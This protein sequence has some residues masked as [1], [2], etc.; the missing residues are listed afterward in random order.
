MQNRTNLL[1]VFLIL[2]VL[3]VLATALMARIPDAAV[4]VQNTH[5][6]E[7]F[8]ALIPICSAAG[9][10]KEIRANAVP[11]C[12]PQGVCGESPTNA[13]PRTLH[14]AARRLHGSNKS[15]VAQFEINK[16]HASEWRPVKSP[17]ILLGD[18]IFESFL[19]TSCAVKIPRAEGC[20]EVLAETYGHYFDALPLAISGDQT[21]H[22][23]WRMP[24]EIPP[25]VRS[26]RNVT[27]LVLIGTNNLGVGH[28][29]GPTADGVRAVVQWL[30]D[31]TLGSVVLLDLL[32]RGD[33]KTL[34][35]LCPPRCNKFGHAFSSFRSPITLVN[36]L[37]EALDCEVQE[38]CEAMA[39]DRLEVVYSC[40]SLFYL[41]RRAHSTDTSAAYTDLENP[42]RQS[43]H[44]R[45]LDDADSINTG[46]MPDRLHPNAE[47]H[48]LLA[49]CLLAKSR[50]L[51][52]RAVRP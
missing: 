11:M 26:Q 36:T 49:Q 52:N 21:Q 12:N 46:L 43:S 1:Y 13:T 19:G 28:L 44:E 4:Q 17:L 41:D 48:R 10:C 6:E 51:G 30:L 23:L 37:L 25:W 39:S 50:I 33:T 38:T 5:E 29:P 35:R 22:L 34:L 27:F 42:T 24:R 18:S 8:E 3:V 9:K 40:G 20:P 45:H 16:R 31:F 32:P 47:G 14:S 15:W 7:E 2:S